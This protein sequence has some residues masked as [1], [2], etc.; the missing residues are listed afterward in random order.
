LGTN[1]QSHPLIRRVYLHFPFCL[2]KCRYCS[3]FSVP[4]DHDLF[5]IYLESIHRELDRWE[6]R[7][8]IRPASIY[9]GG[10]TPSLFPLDDLATLL[11]RFSPEPDAEIT[12]EANPA[13]VDSNKAS[14]W[15]QMG[16]NRVSLGAQ[17]FRDTELTTLG[18]RHNAAD[19]LLA[20]R[21]LRE[22]GLDNLSL[23][24]IYGL[25]NQNR[26]H[27]T[28][29][30]DRLIELAPEHVST[31]CLS[32]ERGT[33]FAR[34]RIQPPADPVVAGFYDLIR[35]KLAVAG[36]RQYEISNFARPGRESRHN[37]CYWNG[38]DYL[39]IGPGASGFVLGVRYRHPAR[40]ESHLLRMRKGQLSV[41][42]DR[43]TAESA[44][45][46]FLMLRLRLIEGFARS[47]Y[48]ARFGEPFEAR[49]GI[50]FH[51]LEKL[52]LIECVNDYIRLTPKALFVSN[53]VIGDLM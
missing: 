2:G 5:E 33:P 14:S 50:A 19:T 30:L 42:R 51:R 11:R 25:P 13:T 53:S 7:L 21:T 43:I 27:L 26:A 4:F 36:F 12:I 29:S 46:E 40:I 47:E 45:E 41:G 48:A 37:L 32:I 9:L 16:V 24:L 52:G 18:R 22:K 49:S 17:S 3:F 20:V 34:E 44:R 15:K 1:V 10:G 39:G 35:E 31:Y 38:E 8:Q 28:D 23:D 6:N